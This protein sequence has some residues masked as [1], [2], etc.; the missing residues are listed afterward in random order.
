MKPTE[1]DT[2][3]LIEL[4]SQ[5]WDEH[6]TPEIDAEIDAIIRKYG[7]EG[8]E[9]LLNICTVHLEVG[10][11]AASARLYA[12]TMGKINDMTSSDLESSEPE[13]VTAVPASARSAS[14]AQL[15]KS[16]VAAA[17]AAAI[18]LAVTGRLYLGSNET[19][20][21][22]VI[23]TVPRG[24]QLLRPSKP[25]ANVVSASQAV[26]APGSEVAVGDTLDEKRHLE[27]LSG[28]AQL[29]MACGADLVLQGPCVMTLVTEDLAELK[30]GK[31]T[32]QASEW[33]TGF[34][35]S[36]DNLKVTDLGTRFALSADGKGVVEAHV[37]D[38]AVL[39]EPLGHR[40]P[41][42]QSVMLHTGQAIRVDGVKSHVELIA[43][44][45]HEFASEIE[46]FRP[47][48]PIRMWNTGVGA[49]VGGTDSH[50][51][52]TSG[53]KDQGPYPKSSVI[54]AGDTGS[55]K[56]N[57]PDVSQW[58][59]VDTDFNAGVPP[60]S[61]HTFETTFDLTGY[62]LSSIYIVGYF[63]V[64]DAINAL[65]INGHPVDFKRWETTWNVYDFRSFHPI[66]IRD[67]FVEGEN[68][69]SIDLYNSPSNP[70]TPEHNNPTALRVEWQAFGLL[71]E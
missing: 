22:G 39:A 1:K 29:S 14:G 12:D 67:H 46:Q 8:G 30:Y 4:L 6:S 70:K 27:L 41:R 48:R 54:T 16:W 63:L 10:R 19:D 58:I 2:N 23:Q 55:Y 44:R 11:R 43:A 24:V 64:D 34:V 71:S 68:V 26:W 33:A 53:S 37:L 40:T 25:I 20:L 62:D 13:V 51:I 28:S 9:L 49:E 35:V 7:P 5:A 32:A 47:L 65:R 61:V 18:M 50:W 66:E 42:Q 3:R 45:Q 36:C 38:G 60:E 21:G 52:I 69:I 15:R 17:L 31:L 59:S 56:D 57:R